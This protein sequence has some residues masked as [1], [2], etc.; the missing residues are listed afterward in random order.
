MVSNLCKGAKWCVARQAA[1]LSLL[2]RD[3]GEKMMLMHIT[4]S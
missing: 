1:R 2:N 3:K 4:V